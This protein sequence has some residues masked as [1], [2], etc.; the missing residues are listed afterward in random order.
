MSSDLSVDINFPAEC[1]R[2]F[3]CA[4]LGL[5]LIGLVN[6]LVSLVG[7]CLGVVPRDDMKVDSGVSVRE[8]RLL[9]VTHGGRAVNVDTYA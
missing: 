7:E 4:G 3:V 6:G 2:A 1:N 5:L 8:G 9:E